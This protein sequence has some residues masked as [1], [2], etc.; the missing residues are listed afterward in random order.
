VK[1]QNKFSAVLCNTFL[2]FPSCL[3]HKLKV[4]FCRLSVSAV[5]MSYLQNPTPMTLPFT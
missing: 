2:G 4:S 3:N 1:K 5:V